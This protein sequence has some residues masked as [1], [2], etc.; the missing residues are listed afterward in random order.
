MRCVHMHDV[1]YN[2]HQIPGVY[3]RIF[4]HLIHILH[5]LVYITDLLWAFWRKPRGSTANSC[6]NGAFFSGPLY[7]AV[8]YL[9]QGSNILPGDILLRTRAAMGPTIAAAAVW[10]FEVSLSEAN[11][12]CGSPVFVG[13]GCSAKHIK[14]T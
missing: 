14:H 3:Q 1:A 5:W 8:E 13:G 4:N 7:T 9:R 6:N 10:Q 11:C 2:L 12:F